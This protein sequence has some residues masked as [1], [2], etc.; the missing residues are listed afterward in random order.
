MVYAS[1]YGST[2]GIAERI[3]SRLRQR[4]HRVELHPAGQVKDVR[5]FD[6][7]S[8]FPMLEVPATMAADIEE[9]TCSLD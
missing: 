1:R 6:A 4:G 9:F 3:A 5:R 7:V 2:V 8:H